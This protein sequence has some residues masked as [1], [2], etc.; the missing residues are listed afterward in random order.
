MGTTDVDLYVKLRIYKKALRSVH[1]QRCS[2]CVSWTKPRFKF[3][4]SSLITPAVVLGRSGSL[5]KLIQRHL[6]ASS[7]REQERPVVYD[8]D[9]E[10]EVGRSS[11]LT[12]AGSVFGL[13]HE[14]HM[15]SLKVTSWETLLWP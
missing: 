1:K 5:A 10:Q 6:L 3:Q 12:P 8:G 7:F 14:H 11:D 4:T 13:L 15:A 2:S 9:G